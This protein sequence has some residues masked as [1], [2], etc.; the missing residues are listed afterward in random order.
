MAYLEIREQYGCAQRILLERNLQAVAEGP[1][2]FGRCANQAYKV[3][4]RSD[5]QPGCNGARRVPAQ[6]VGHKVKT[7]IGIC[8][9]TILIRLTLATSV[10]QC[11]TMDH[12]LSS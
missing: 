12:S 11:G 4:D 3:I 7:A 9:V 2:H 5:R 6:S 1:A 8:K 10:R